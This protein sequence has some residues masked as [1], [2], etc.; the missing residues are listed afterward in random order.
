VIF[1]YNRKIPRYF[2]VI[3]EKYLFLCVIS[4]EMIHREIHT[5]IENEFFK[6]KAIILLGARQVGKSTLLKQIL[7]NNEQVLWLD[8]ENPDIPVLLK[9]INTSRL[10]QI[11]GKK[12][13]LVIDEAQKLDHIGQTLK[14]LTDHLKDIQ[15]IATGSSSFELKNQLNE[16]LTGRKFEHTLF[17][18]NFTEMVNHLGLLEEMRLLPHRLVFGSYPEVITTQEPPEK[19]L[20]LIAESYLYKDIFLFRGVRKPQKMMELLK[21][22][23]WQIGSEVNY[24]ELSN[25]TGLNNETIEDYIH[26]LEQA[27]VIYKLPSF[28]TNQR[29]ELKKGKKI[30]FYDLGIRNAII[31]D[32]SVFETRNDKGALFENYVINQLIS[33]NSYA[34]NF[35]SFFFWRTTNQ[36]EVDLVIKKNN[37]IT[38]LEIKWN[39][40]KLKT[41]SLAF[42]NKYPNHKYVGIHSQNF[43]D[44]L[45]PT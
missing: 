40:K 45:E 10:R 4:L 41:G 1:G 39:P 31:D 21:A 27:F 2:S 23:A 3:T 22:L 36:Q 26:L 43:Y 12:K 38:A 19:I 11:I 42:K 14:L 6:G 17:P 29:T 16:P 24:N 20:R 35:Q 13:I 8:V 7:G 15:V 37:E 18:V 44:F 25:L 9:D 34:D 28:H 5:K 30:Y 33:K 32:F